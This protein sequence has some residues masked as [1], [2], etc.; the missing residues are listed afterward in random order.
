MKKIKETLG[1]QPTNSGANPKQSLLFAGLDIALINKS[2]FRYWVFKYDEEAGRLLPFS[3]GDREKVRRSLEDSSETRWKKKK[4]KIKFYTELAAN[5]LKSL[6]SY[7]F[8]KAVKM[9]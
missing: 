2:K 6:L 3:W 5:T 8:P 7:F 9:I 1:S 4:E